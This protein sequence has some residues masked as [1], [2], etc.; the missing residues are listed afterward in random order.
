[1]DGVCCLGELENVDVAQKEDAAA[2]IC[3]VVVTV[4]LQA[5]SVGARHSLTAK[6]YKEWRRLG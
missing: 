1:M 3:I 4:V 2:V 5:M 6:S